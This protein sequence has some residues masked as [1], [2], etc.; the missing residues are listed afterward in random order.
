[1]KIFFTIVLLIILFFSFNL[2]VDENAMKIH[3]DALQRTMV[4]FGLAKGLNGVISLIQSTQISFAPIGVGVNVT[5][6]EILDP[7]N[8]MV[9]RFSWI[10]LL[11]SVSLGIQKLL[12]MLSSKVFIQVAL[13]LSITFTIT[14]VWVKKITSNRIMSFSFQLLALF[15]LLRFASLTF[16]Y[17]NEYFYDSVLKTE[18]VASSEVVAQ[19]KIELEE[20]NNNNKKMITKKEDLKWYEFNIN[21]KYNDLKDSLDFTQ[22]LNG[23]K[24]S[25]E[26]SSNKIINLITIF[27]VQSVVMPLLFLWL[28]VFL[29]RAIFKFD[30]HTMV[31]SKYQ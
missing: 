14:V 2:Q 10:M 11:S 13:A 24:N 7:F 3:D 31:Y 8:D 25:I 30:Y 17:A 20:F 27:V 22:K 4:A 21:E 29:L 19:S 5:V 26:Q 16:V 18:F 9:E 6:G 1:M 23:L 28:F 15:I 12:L